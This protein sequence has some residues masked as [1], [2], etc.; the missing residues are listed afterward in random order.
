M[1]GGV[2][3]LI[4]FPMSCVFLSSVFRPRCNCA[5]VDLGRTRMCWPWE[6]SAMLCF[7]EE[8]LCVCVCVCV[9]ECFTSVMLTVCFG[10]S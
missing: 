10:L 7:S 8:S 9:C 6:I 4:V 5:V 1:M 2:L 3:L